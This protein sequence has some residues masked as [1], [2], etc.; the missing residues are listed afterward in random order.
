MK[1]VTVEVDGKARP[2]RSA[3]DHIIDLSG[4]GPDLRSILESGGLDRARYSGKPI[5][6]RKVF[7]RGSSRSI[8]NSG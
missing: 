1:L 7:N 6:L 5:C 4:I 2:G 3:D 8:A